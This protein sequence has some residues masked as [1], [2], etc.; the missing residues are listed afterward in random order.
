MFGLHEEMKNLVCA[1]KGIWAG[2]RFITR[3]PTQLPAPQL[4]CGIGASLSGD[5][6]PRSPPPIFSSEKV[7]QNQAFLEPPAFDGCVCRKSDSAILMVK[8]AKDRS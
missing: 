7:L 5:R 4:N 8:A 2:C 6:I 1:G 3:R